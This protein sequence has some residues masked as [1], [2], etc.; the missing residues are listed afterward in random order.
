MF[1]FL[2]RFCSRGS[3][4]FF[5]R[6]T[7]IFFKSIYHKLHTSFICLCSP[8]LWSWMI[9]YAHTSS[10]SAVFCQRQVLHCKRRNQGCTSAEGRSS[11]ANPETNAAVLPGMNRYDSF[12]CFRHPTLLLASEQTLKDLKRS[13][14]HH[15][16]GEESGFG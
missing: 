1:I 13:Q 10:S 16:G 5:A 11:T 14:G 9:V 8:P 12:P 6:C 2:R 7:T 15:L 4:K 3:R